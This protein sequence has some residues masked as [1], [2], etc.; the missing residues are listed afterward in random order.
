[1]RLIRRVIKKVPRAFSVVT[2]PFNLL[3][4]G[5]IELLYFKV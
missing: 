5:E 1:M 3:L 2:L 4:A